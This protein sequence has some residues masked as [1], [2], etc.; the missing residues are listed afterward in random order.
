[1]RSTEIPVE[2]LDAGSCATARDLL[3]SCVTRGLRL[4]PGA[5]FFGR[6]NE[7]GSSL[8]RIALTRDAPVVSAAA[9]ILGHALFSEKNG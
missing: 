3:D 4:L 5:S 6:P 7:S 8:L 9:E 1:M 2:W